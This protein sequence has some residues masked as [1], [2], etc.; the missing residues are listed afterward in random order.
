MAQRPLWS[1]E[2]EVGAFKGFQKD[3]SLLNGASN[4]SGLIVSST[5]PTCIFSGPGPLQQLS[6]CLSLAFAFPQVVSLVAFCQEQLSKYPPAN[7]WPM[8]PGRL[9]WALTD[10]SAAKGGYVTYPLRAVTIRCITQHQTC[11]IPSYSC[12]PTT[13]PFP[14]LF[15][16][17]VSLASPLLCPNK[18]YLY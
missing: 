12:F 7:S 14:R 13:L 9:S 15:S 5:E 10:S 3:C 11:V 1:P 17:Q 4:I 8:L 16:S 18:S 6:T 2:S